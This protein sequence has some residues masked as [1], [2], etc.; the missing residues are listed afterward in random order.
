MP[1]RHQLLAFL[2]K[3]S[4]RL[5]IRT[6]PVVLYIGMLPRWS[7]PKQILFYFK[8]FIHGSPCRCGGC[9]EAAS[10]LPKIH[11]KEEV[12]AGL[13]WIKIYA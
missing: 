5:S 1:Q 13:R 9:V 12:T 7:L 6:V 3:K 2:R 8:V 10:Q 4:K 11:T